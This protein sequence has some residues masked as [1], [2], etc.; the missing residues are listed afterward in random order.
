MDIFITLDDAKAYGRRLARHGLFPTI[1]KKG[2]EYIVIER[3]V[4]PPRGSWPF[5]K[6]VGQALSGCGDCVEWMP[7]LAHLD[8]I[9]RAQEARALFAVLGYN[10][11]IVLFPGITYDIFLSEAHI[12]EG[13]DVI[14]L[15]ADRKPLTQIKPSRMQE[16][17]NEES[18]EIQ[19]HPI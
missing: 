5:L 2:S 7:V 10:P 16:E 1:Y 18:F 14:F 9:E 11:V 8:S 12:P 4:W 13:A 3:G 6:W 19:V 15:E 17:D